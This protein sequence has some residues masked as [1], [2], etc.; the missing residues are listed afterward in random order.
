MKEPHSLIV[1]GT[2]GIGRELVDHFVRE[3][4]KVSVIARRMPERKATRGRVRYWQADVRDESA[5]GAV[6]SRLV[7]ESGKINHLVFFQRYRGDDEAWRGEIETS[8]TATKTVVET[9]QD[10][11][12]AGEKSIVLVSSINAALIAGYLP[13]GYHV[14]KAALR[15]MVRYWAVTLGARG[16][17]VNSVS[18]GTVLKEESKSFFLRDKKLHDLYRRITPLGRFGHAREVAQ[19]IGCLCGDQTSFVTGQDI[20]VDGG[21][22]LQWQESLA[23]ELSGLHH[24]PAG[25][26]TKTRK[27]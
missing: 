9:M 4:H 26:G 20:V 12:A 18:P 16:I 25:Q 13:L 1:G 11:F 2:R 7:K 3:G 19:V 17:R 14:A 24:P 22:S 6:L 23:R 8:L 10:K 15:Q 21:V 5:L 27:K